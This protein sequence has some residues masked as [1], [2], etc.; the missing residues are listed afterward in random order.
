LLEEASSPSTFLSPIQ[1]FLFG[2]LFT[3]Q[4]RGRQQPEDDSAA[5]WIAKPKKLAYCIRTSHK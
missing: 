1:S 2:V 3:G 5:G 4:E